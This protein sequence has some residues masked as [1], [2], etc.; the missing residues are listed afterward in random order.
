MSA[1]TATGDDAGHDDHEPSGWRRWVF[2]T[3]HEDV[4]IIYLWL[5]VF[6]FIM[7]GALAMLFR[8]ELLTPADGPLFNLNGY[9]ALFS[10]HGLTMIFLV[11]VPAGGVFANYLLPHYLGLD[12]MA[13][14]RLNALSGWLVFWGGVMLWFPVVGNALG[15]T[16]LP[17]NGGWFAYPPLVS[18]FQHVTISSYVFSMVILGISTTVAGINFMVTLLN[19]RDPS[20][21]LFDLPFGAWGLGIFTPLLGLYELPWLMVGVSFD[22][23]QN[24]LGMGFFDARTGGAPLL[25][26]WLFWLFGHPEVYFVAMPFLAIVGEIV[27]RFSERP[28]Y[29]Y[30]SVIYAITGIT[31]MSGMVWAH[32]MYITG[33]GQIRYLYMF[34]SMAIPIMF[35]VYIFAM[36]AMMWGGRIHF[37]TPMLFSIGMLFMLIYSGMDG[38]I[39][40]QTPVDVLIHS[41][42][43]IVGHFHFTLFGVAIMGFFAALYYYYPRMTG[44]MYSERLG[45]L[46][47][48]LTIVCAPIVFTLMDMMGTQAVPMMRR[49]ATY[50]YAPG[51]QNL[52]I[53]TTAFAYVLGIAQ[54][55]MAAN[56]LWSLWYGAEVENPWSELLEGQ[57]MPSPEW[58]GLPYEVP[59]PAN[60]PYNPGGREDVRDEGGPVAVDGGDDPVPDGGDGEVSDDE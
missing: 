6:W 13:F 51:L 12:E 57:G 14:P 37:K 48:G 31:L 18:R 52:Q 50:T 40:S 39:M 59:T 27:P 28:V 20:L 33:L 16:P 3:S 56:L 35:A 38:I 2:T 45:K 7:G 17:F 11:A 15:L 8:T 1:E 60:V 36:F 43:F 54:V 19:E 53:A 4:G 25:W 46:H 21:G 55:V 47:A 9:N 42:W 49:Y 10:L 22:F 44:R 30:R 34:F 26:Q 32:H 58:N 24:T 23:L 41:T 5:A 29:G